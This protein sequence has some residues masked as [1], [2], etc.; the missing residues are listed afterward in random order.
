MDLNRG[1]SNLAK[2]K[3]SWYLEKIRFYLALLNNLGFYEK[4]LGPIA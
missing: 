1:L 4:V 3:Y 2:H